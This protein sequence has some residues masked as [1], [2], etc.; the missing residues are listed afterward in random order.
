VVFIQLIQGAAQ[1]EDDAQAAVPLE[2]AT[3]YCCV[4]QQPMTGQPSS[5]SPV[6]LQPTA[7]RGI[8]R[9][10]SRFLEPVLAV[11]QPLVSVLQAAAYHR[12]PEVQALAARCLSHMDQ[13]AAVVDALGDEQQRSWW[14]M[15]FQALQDALARSRESAAA[16]RVTLQERRG[17][18][19]RSLYRLLWGY[20]DEELRG[21]AAGQLVGYLEHQRLE[22]RVLSIAT[23]QQITGKTLGYSPWV[24]ERQ[25]RRAVAA[26]QRLEKSDQVAYRAASS[27]VAAVEPR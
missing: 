6:W 7:V 9:D 1:L 15:H 18:D 23:L 19:A 20:T 21:G 16:L 10:A 4:D 12:R 17:S 13:F 22:F 8:D 14:G 24:P 26:W 27:G 11:D 5:D 2:P 25:R 3:V